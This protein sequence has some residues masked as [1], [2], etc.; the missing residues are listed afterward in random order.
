MQPRSL[1]DTTAGIAPKK[2]KTGDGPGESV[3]VLTVVV[4]P[5]VGRIG[6]RSLLT[7]LPGKSVGLSRAE[8]YFAQPG[9]GGGEPLLDPFLSRGPVM[10]TGK[11]DGSVVLDASGTRT[12]VKTNG[13]T[14]RKQQTF[15]VPQL[16]YGVILILADRI[17]LLLHL[18]KP[19]HAQC[20]EKYGLVGGSSAM[21]RLREEVTRL[22]DQDIPVLLRGETGTG[23]EL[24]AQALHKYGPRKEGKLVSVNLGA[25]P[26]G[27]ETSELFGSI[28]GAFSG[29]V[30][31][32]EGYFR[33]AQGGTLF[34]DEI[35]E[36]SSDLQRN[37]LRAVENG[38]IFPVGSQQPVKIDVRLISATDADLEAEAM[39]G[40]FKDPVYYRLAGYEIWLPP[41]S[42]RRDD[43]GRLFMHFA[44]KDLA[45]ID[46]TSKLEPPDKDTPQWLPAELG[47]RLCAFH[48]PG[49]VRQLRNVVRQLVIANRDSPQ[50]TETP[51]VKYLLDQAEPPPEA[52]P[53]KKKYCK[54]SEITREELLAAYE[55]NAFEPK[56]T[57]AQL[58]ISRT[59]I[60]ALIDKTPG[61][62]TA[63]DL[64]DETVEQAFEQCNGDVEAMSARLKVSERALRYRIKK[65]KLND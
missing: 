12:K 33:A 61:I 37:L 35:G 24:L 53:Q 51:K 47:A 36:A 22:A 20:T 14:I 31:A 18:A 15:T 62:Q 2:G 16:D 41:L 55:A 50:L 58:N 60:Y 59:S 27:L 19:P 57:A 64:S 44:E 10:L 11:T 45:S 29:S 34:L 5:D 42:Q 65:L 48:W 38:E 26:S 63:A 30:S 7:M 25:I 28:R 32:Q 4:H 23:K 6:E 21:A 1:F 8:P 49:N 3:V 40:N 9:A 52:R 13:S 43:I 56:A 17:T 39:E 54:P 46:A